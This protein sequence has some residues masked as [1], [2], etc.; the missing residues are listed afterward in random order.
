MWSSPGCMVPLRSIVNGCSTMGSADGS[1]T[2]DRARARGL[3]GGVSYRGRRYGLT[4]RTHGDG[5][6][7]TI[8][9]EELG[10]TDVVSANIYRVSSG[11]MLRA[12]EMPD[13]KVLDSS[14]PGEPI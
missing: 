10:G 6:I 11:D 1:R 14:A 2:S 9:A 5:R 12:C 3:V 7:V 4:R 8:Y 13:A